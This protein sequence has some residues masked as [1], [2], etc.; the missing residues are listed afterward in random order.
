MSNSGTKK[1]HGVLVIPLVETSPDYVNNLMATVRHYQWFMQ[2]TC[3][4]N[5]LEIDSAEVFNRMYKL[6]DVLQSFRA[7]QLWGQPNPHRYFYRDDGS[8]EIYVEI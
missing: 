8:M 2:F 3:K 1:K 4:L 5:L 7:H 6:E